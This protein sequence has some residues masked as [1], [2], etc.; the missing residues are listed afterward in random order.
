MSPRRLGQSRVV[1]KIIVVSAERHSV[2]Q[3]HFRPHDGILVECRKFACE[4]IPRLAHD[5]HKSKAE[6]AGQITHGNAGTMCDHTL[7][8]QLSAILLLDRDPAPWPYIQVLTGDVM[9][10]SLPFGAA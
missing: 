5:T 8:V 10:L 1:P 6:F 9:S 4:N 2:S 3:W 7:Q